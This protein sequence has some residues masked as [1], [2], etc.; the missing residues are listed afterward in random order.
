VGGPVTTDFCVKV[1]GPNVGIIVA[2]EDELNSTSNI[3]LAEWLH[4]TLTGLLSERF[5]GERHSG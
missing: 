4:R 1:T 5:G 2:T 3:P